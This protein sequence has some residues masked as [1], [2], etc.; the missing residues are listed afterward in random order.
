MLRGLEGVV[1]P[2]G[3]ISRRLVHRPPRR[4]SLP[5]AGIVSREKV[6]C[7]CRTTC[8]TLVVHNNTDATLEV[9][10]VGASSSGINTPT[11]TISP[12]T[13][14]EVY[15]QFGSARLF[16]TAVKVSGNPE[17][18]KPASVF[19]KG[20]TNPTLPPGFR[21]LRSYHP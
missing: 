19:K 5:A 15:V 17:A 6:L 4:Q 7:G 20:S 12:V 13:V 14:A 8:A 21:R 18:V 1:E 2:R 9:N 11:Y 16:A 10:V 3:R